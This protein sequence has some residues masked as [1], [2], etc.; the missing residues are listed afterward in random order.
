MTVISVLDFDSIAEGA[1]VTVSAPWSALGVKSTAVAAASTHGARGARWS[2]TDAYGRIAYDFGVNQFGPVVLSWYMQVRAFS[3]STPLYVASATNL[4]TG[5]SVLGHV[6]INVAAKTVSIRNG[7]TAIATSTPTLS[8]N[9]PYRFEWRLD[10]TLSTQTL[11]VFAGE[12]ATAFIALAG[13]WSS[14]ETRMLVFGPDIAATGGAVDYD[15][16]RIA[17]DWMGPFGSERPVTA[18]RTYTASG[19]KPVFVHDL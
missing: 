9:T 3:G 7:V 1:A 11:R 4:P 17:D 6:R 15:T 19:W 18:W 5:G 12:S 14:D 10:A 16:V 13:A 8:L 2:S